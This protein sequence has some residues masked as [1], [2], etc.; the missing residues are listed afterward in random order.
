MALG[1]EL[2]VDV[3]V[4]AAPPVPVV[5]ADVVKLLSATYSKAIPMMGARV[6][7]ALLSMSA[8]WLPS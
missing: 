2:L 1:L 5:F 6:P 3:D 7:L 4:A 8:C